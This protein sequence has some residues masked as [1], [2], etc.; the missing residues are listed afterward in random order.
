MKV[1]NSAKPEINSQQMPD[2]DKSSAP[3]SDLFFNLIMDAATVTTPST[4]A[5]PTKA[6]DKKELTQTANQDDAAHANPLFAMFN[7]IDKIDDSEIV[8]EQ[9]VPTTSTTPETTTPITQQQNTQQLNDNKT[10]NEV[11]TVVEAQLGQINELKDKNAI[12][13]DAALLAAMQTEDN[14]TNL[15]DKIIPVSDQ[16]AEVL[17]KMTNT[18]EKPANLPKKLTNAKIDN[19]LEISTDVPTSKM[20]KPIQSQTAQPIM[21]VFDPLKDSTN[22]QDNQS[23]NKYMDALAQMGNLINAQ[24]MNHFAYDGKM[25]PL[26]ANNITVNDYANSLRQAQLEPEEPTI[27]LVTTTLNAFNKDS[28]DAKIKIYPPELGH[29]LAK[30]K[31]NQNNA[32]LVIT[33]ENNRVKEIVEANLPQLREQFQRSDINLASIQVDVAPPQT[34]SK[35]QDSNNQRHSEAFQANERTNDTEQKGLSPKESART[36][37]TLVDTYA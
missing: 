17:S 16:L 12:S 8:P 19:K 14:N 30:L 22:F 10:I 33:T 23:Q 6:A 15:T 3:A 11:N 37:N 2:S 32:D 35:D 24:T 20:T 21:T 5:E 13:S 29:V 9:Q 26:N 36:L 31:M 4:D 27:E 7:M 25:L 34:S 28:Y 1:Q 18:S